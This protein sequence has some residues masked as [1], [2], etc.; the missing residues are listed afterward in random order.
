MA[1]YFCAIG[2]STRKGHRINTW[3][4]TIGRCPDKKTAMRRAVR[5]AQR[6]YPGMIYKVVS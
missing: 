5:N 4:Q 2:I 3:W 6:S 1:D